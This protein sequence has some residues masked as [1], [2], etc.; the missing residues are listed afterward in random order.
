MQYKPIIIT[1]FNFFY[2]FFFLYVIVK[3]ISTFL[4][5]FTKVIIL[6]PA[7]AV[8]MFMIKA[9]RPETKPTKITGL[10]IRSKLLK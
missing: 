9:G 4:V 1:Y 8:S 2:A 5:L 6:G 7:S 3:A 10:F